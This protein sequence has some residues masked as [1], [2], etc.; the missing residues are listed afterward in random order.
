VQPSSPV[1]APAFP[2]Q[3]RADRAVRVLVVDDN[4]DGADMIAELLGIAGFDV[5]V[6]NDPSQALAAADVF[7]PQ[8]AIVDLGLP[9]MDGYSLGRE[10]RSRLSDAPPIFIALTGYG[11]EQDRVRS[12]EAGFAFHLVK[13]VDAAQLVDLLETLLTPA[14]APSLPRPGADAT[15]LST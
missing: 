6:V 13:P 2:Q 10:L 5:R 3:P 14:S 7:R 11:Q 8:V 4:R 9:V 1:R 15:P 12:T